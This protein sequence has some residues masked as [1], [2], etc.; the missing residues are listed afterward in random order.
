M[1]KQNLFSKRIRTPRE[2][3]AKLPF[4]PAE[5]S[6]FE[7]HLKNEV[8]SLTSAQEAVI[9]IHIPFCNR[10]CD[11]C[12]YNRISYD[13]EM[14]ERYI[15]K[16]IDHVKQAAQYPLLKNRT[17]SAVYFGGGSPGCI[18]P[19][20]II[21]VLNELQTHFHLSEECEIT[22]EFT[23]SDIHADKLELLFRNGFN[24][25][26]A[27][28]QSFD[29]RLRQNL[30][31]ILDGKQVAE[32]LSIATK[33]SFKNICIDLI[34]N[35][36]GQTL[37]HWKTD[38][39]ELAK[40]HIPACSVYPLIPFP[41]SALVKT[42]GYKEPDLIEE[43]R[44]FKLAD[45]LLLNQNNWTCF[46]PVQYGHMP[47]G[48][49]KY[50]TGIARNADILGFGCGAYGVFDHF[51]YLNTGGPE[52]FM[53]NLNPFPNELTRIF[54]IDK[55]YLTCQKIY[56]LAEG[57]QITEECIND[58]S[59]SIREAI[60]ILLQNKLIEKEAN[61]YVLNQ[62]GRFWAGNILDFLVS[63]SCKAT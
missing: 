60:Q 37:S 9:Y 45:V 31:R 34:Y 52:D 20:Q 11:F 28:V 7:S 33:S 63:A 40:L 41:N 5:R 13:E 35:I 42:Q 55:S 26:S 62:E 48:N 27:G 25:I 50:I 46:T 44:F 21:D 58:Q 38:L 24:R 49:S 29:T 59:G 6:I 19:A 57:A 23:L 39:E 30:G 12:G 32:K 15:R 54:S 16:V 3:K 53:Q 51:Q 18:Q 36:P 17:F 10:I 61:R 1:E 47:G 22:I 56:E 8:S 4:T 2:A 14:A 43:Y